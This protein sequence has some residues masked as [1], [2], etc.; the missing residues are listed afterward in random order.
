MIF[1]TSAPCSASVRA[2]VGPARTRVRSSTRMP[3]SGR[4]PCGQLFRRRVADLDDFQQR[5]RG[6]RRGL[7]MLRPFRH[8]AHHAAGA[9][10]GDDRLLEFER[11]PFRDG[12]AHR[13]LVLLAAEHAQRGGAVV[14]EIGVDIAPAAVLR[15]IDAHHRVALGR[16]LGPVH[17]EIV[18][19]AQ[20]MRRLAAD[21]PRPAACG[22]C[23]VPTDRRPPARSRRARR[24][25]SRRC[26]TGSARPGRRRR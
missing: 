26:G 10:G 20:A 4:S 7:R 12:A 14:R 6:D 3:E 1:N 19:A 13:V 2:Q 17:H 16:D 5:Q 22:R 24:R 18:A 9:L 15:R 23:A 25:R 11:V 21:R 8:A